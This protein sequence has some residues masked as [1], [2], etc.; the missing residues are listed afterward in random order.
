MPSFLGLGNKTKQGM[1][2][3]SHSMKI[4]ENL[5]KEKYLFHLYLII[6]IIG[7]YILRLE[8]LWHDSPELDVNIKLP[9]VSELYISQQ[10]HLSD[11]KAFHRQVW[12]L[13][14]S[15]SGQLPVV[16]SSS[17]DNRSLCTEN[18]ELCSQGKNFLD[19]TIFPNPHLLALRMMG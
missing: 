2:I 19:P 12:L 3:S 4:P 15:S 7:Q 8:K 5:L 14:S 9:V 17:P 1:Y 10:Y 16:M 6:S 11:L 13:M 18:L